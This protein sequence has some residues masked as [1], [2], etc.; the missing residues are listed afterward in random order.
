MSNPAQSSPLATLA[1]LVQVLLRGWLPPPHVTVQAP[2]AV[3]GVQLPSTLKPL[4]I[5]LKGCQNFFFTV[6]ELRVAVLLL[7]ERA[8]A[9]QTVVLRRGRGAGAR[10]LLLA[11]AAAVRAVGPGGPIGEP[12]VD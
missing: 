11:A 3:H 10:V 7:L 12:S 4:I 5:T 6:A 2:Q 8:G 9:V 1:G